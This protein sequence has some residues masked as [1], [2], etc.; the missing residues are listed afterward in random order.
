MIYPILSAF[1]SFFFANLW[2]SFDVGDEDTMD[3]VGERL[4]NRMA[5]YAEHLEDG[6]AARNWGKMVRLEIE[7][8]ELQNQLEEMNMS[9]SS[10]AEEQVTW[11]MLLHVSSLTLIFFA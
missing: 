5:L 9:K 3:W 1:T 7:F 2:R 4:D 6:E 10:S 8:D 11:Y